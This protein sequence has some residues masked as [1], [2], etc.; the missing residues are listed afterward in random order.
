MFFNKLNV[1]HVTF[2][3][4]FFAKDPLVLQTFY[5]P[6]VLQNVNMDVCY[7]AKKELTPQAEQTEVWTWW[8][9]LFTPP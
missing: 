8:A 2:K 1:L 9:K 5:K 3:G 7:S 6:L 4:F